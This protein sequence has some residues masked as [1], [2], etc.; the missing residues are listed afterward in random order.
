MMYPA[1]CVKTGRNPSCMP[2]I[3]KLLTLR[4]L[5]LCGKLAPAEPQRSQRIFLAA[6]CLLLTAICLPLTAHA[7]STG[8]AKG[9]VRNGRNEPVAGVSVTARQDSKDIKTVESNGKGEFTITGLEPGIYS[10]IFDAAGYAAAMRSNIEIRRNKTVDLG[11]RLV[12]RVDKGTLVIIQGSVFFK[13]GTSVTAAKIE[14]EKVDKDGTTRSFPALETSYS[15]EFTFTQR[16]G[17]AKYRFTAKYKDKTASKEIEVDGAAVYRLAI[18]LDAT[19]T[20]R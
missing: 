13:D 14:V 9:K 1:N 15:G 5:R 17:A 12:L 18:S 2:K 7:Q 8:A 16:P 11:D 19:R 6:F 10:F 20:E 3:R 4:S